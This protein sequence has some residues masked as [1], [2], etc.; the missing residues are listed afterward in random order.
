MIVLASGTV[1]PKRIIYIKYKRKKEE[2]SLTPESK[3]IITEAIRWHNAYN[4]SEDNK[5]SAI[6]APR[7]GAIIAEIED[8]DKMR[9][10]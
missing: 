1:G 7:N 10:I 2:K 6:K 9:P 5:R 8:V 3:S 4:F